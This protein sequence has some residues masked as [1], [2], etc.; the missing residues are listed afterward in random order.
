V[1]ATSFTKDIRYNFAG[2]KG[3]KNPSQILE[4]RI[5]Y[6]D[7]EFR[8]IN[9]PMS[10]YQESEGFG[11][12]NTIA[13]SI[14]GSPTVARPLGLPQS[15]G[16]RETEDAFVESDKLVLGRKTEEV[17]SKIPFVIKQDKIA[18]Q[19]FKRLTTIRDNFLTPDS[20]RPIKEGGMGS[21]EVQAS[22]AY[23]IIR[24]LVRNEFTET[25]G[26]VKTSQTT[27]GRL[28]KIATDRAFLKDTE[29]NPDIANFIPEVITSLERVGSKEKA[30]ALKILEN[31]FNYLR[32]YQTGDGGGNEE[33]TRITG[34]QTKAVDAIRDLVG[35][36]YRD[37]ETKKRIGLAKGGLASR[38]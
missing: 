11:D 18:S 6:A 19:G 31:Q 36:T 22:T 10:K 23:R 12:M 21:E 4:T 37:K 7:Y 9:M 32:K 24:D 34:E 20:L 35:G 29:I 5:P 2:S 17:A 8:R 26:L 3:G 13:R 14:T 15:V 25:K 27:L 30:E 16:L 1:G 38:R 33:I 28:R